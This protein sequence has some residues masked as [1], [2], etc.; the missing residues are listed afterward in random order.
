[1]NYSLPP[2]HSGCDTPL[3]PEEAEEE[4]EEAKEGGE[5]KAEA[6]IAK[7]LKARSAPSRCVKLCY[8][9][10]HCIIKDVVLHCSMLYH[11]A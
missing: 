5:K 6:L 1:M 9:V 3:S 10:S 8:V 4:A 7:A 11:V 2:P